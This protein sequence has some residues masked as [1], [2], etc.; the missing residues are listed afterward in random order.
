VT[1]GGDDDSELVIAIPASITGPEQR[2]VFD[3]VEAISD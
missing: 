2:S 3:R 1:F